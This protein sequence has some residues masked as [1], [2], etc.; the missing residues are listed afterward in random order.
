MERNARELLKKVLPPTEAA[1]LDGKLVTKRGK[2]FIEIVCYAKSEEID[3]IVMGTHGRGPIAH[4]L[5][6]SVA[7]KLVRQAPC[8]VLTVRHPEHE[9]VMP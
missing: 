2:P 9:F 3:L 8:P 5:M 7:E 1:K 4:M 6:G